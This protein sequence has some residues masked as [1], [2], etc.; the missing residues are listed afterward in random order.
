MARGRLLSREDPALG[1][2]LRVVFEEEGIAVLTDTATHGVH[3]DGQQFQL[4]TDG[5]E[6][7]GDR[8]LLATGRRPNTAALGL[9]RAGVATDARGAIVVDGHLRT[10][11][12]NIYAVGD[13]THLPRFVDVAA[14]GT[15]AARNMSGED[16]ALDLS[17][18]PAVVFS[19]PQVATVGLDEV[20]AREQGIA[21]ESRTLTLDNVPRALADFDTRGFIKLVAARDGGRILGCQVLADGGGEIIQSAALAIAN[22][23]TVGG[24]ADQLF[25]YL[26]LAEGLK[27]RA[28]T[29]RKD[30]SRLSCCAG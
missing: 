12:A 9:L 19:E 8:L 15:R 24:L 13:C 4:D 20:Q 11:T 5:G 23:M 17:V 26:T 28:Q 6:I 16:V 27:L 7:R 29:F 30:V 1:G 3:H 21:V 14:A 2:G 10:S 18:L 22:G 25:P